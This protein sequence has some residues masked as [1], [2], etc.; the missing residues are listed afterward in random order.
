MFYIPAGTV[1]S[2]GAGILLA[3]VQQSS[4]I[5]YRIFDWNRSGLNGKPRPLHTELALK[6][7]RWDAR[8][9]KVPDNH[10]HTPYFDLD[11]I[12]ISN[13][14]N[15]NFSGPCIVQNIGTVNLKTGQHTLAPGQT[16]VF[17]PGN[18]TFQA[19]PSTQILVTSL[20]E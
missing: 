1:H 7:I 15:F 4:D 18:H 20:S 6:A 17:W 13:P 8:P 14:Q 5:T 10:L 11:E 12:K 3:E 19:T 16:A 2:I 9:E